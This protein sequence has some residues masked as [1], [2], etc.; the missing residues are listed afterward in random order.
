MK[1]LLVWVALFGLVGCSDPKGTNPFL[2]SDAAHADAGGDTASNNGGPNNGGQNNG[3]CLGC[4]TAAG[5]CVDGDESSAC[6]I[7][8]GSCVACGADQVC[9]PDGACVATPSCGPANCPGC[10]DAAGAC[11]AGN[12]AVACGTGGI[13]CGTCPG[14]ATCENGSCEQPCG[15]E[16]C[17]GCC[18]AAGLCVHG[19]SDGACGTMG[20]A[21]EDCGA[22]GARC[23]GSACVQPSCADNCAGCC[24]GSTCI[25]TGSDTQCGSAGDACMDCGFGRSCIVGV[26]AVD[27]ASS[28]TVRVT[29]GKIAATKVGGDS[30]DGFNGLPDGVVTLSTTDP[31]GQEITGSTSTVDNSLDPVWNEDVLTGVPARALFDGLTITFSDSDTAFDDEICVIQE[32]V[33]MSHA[34]FSGGVVESACANQPESKVRWR[35]VAE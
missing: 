7:G 11:I 27:A 10:C 19:D 1:T 18:D 9:G 35:L 22:T 14:Q 28:W 15:P 34:A 5:D 17:A 8:G 16:N 4:V 24:E 13:T 6:G 25:E 20:A 21:C 32:T 33:N 31:V 26:C 2:D 3:P 12:T 23:A 30:W 29:D